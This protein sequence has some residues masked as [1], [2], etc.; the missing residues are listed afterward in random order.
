MN[1]HWL[2]PQQLA[3]SSIQGKATSSMVT[4]GVGV[5]ASAIGASCSGA[6]AKETANKV[7]R[8]NNDLMDFMI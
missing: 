7:N 3:A 8:A 4:S 6:Q 1:W 5:G 2:S